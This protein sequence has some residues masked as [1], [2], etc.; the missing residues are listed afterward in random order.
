MNIRKL[1]ILSFC[2]QCLSLISFAQDIRTIETKVADLLAQLPTTDIQSTNKLMSDMILLGDGGIKQI[3]D[4][5]KPLGSGDDIRPRF[6]VESLSRYLSQYGKESEKAK[7]EQ[8]CI[9]YAT[10]QKDYTVNDFYMKQLQLVGSI[11][12][13][14]AIKGYLTDKNLNS[15]ALAVISSVGGPLAETV[16]SEALKD[17]MLPCAAA[18]MNELA[19]MKSNVAVNEF[20]AWSSNSDKSIQASA[21]NA[22][23]Q[24]GSPLALPVLLKA[25]KS[26]SYKWE[27]TGATASLLV[28]TKAIGAKGD[29]KT[30]DKICKTIITNCNDR[31]SIQYKTSALETLVNY[32]GYE[33]MPY[34]L[35]AARHQD[36]TYRNAAYLFSLSLAG[37]QVTRKWI[38]YYPEAAPA[39]KP[40]IIYMLGIRKDDLA[41]PLMSTSLTDA[42]V[43]VRKAAAEAIVK[44]NGID[45]IHSLIDYMIKFSGN[46]DQESAKSALMTVVDNRRMPLLI[47]V[48][49]AGPDAAKKSAIELFAWGKGQEYFAAVLPFTAYGEENVKIAA[50][51]ALCDIAGPGDQEKLIQLLNKTE[52]PVLISNVQLALANAANQE[53]DPEKRSST[54]L[55]SMITNRNKGMI[56]PILSRTGGKDALATVLKEFDNGDSEVRDVCFKALTSWKDYSASSA[57]Y[58]I[59][60]THNK[61]YEEAAFDGYVRQIKSA[62]VPDEQRLLLYR[63]IMP[64]AMSADLK[65]QIITEISKIKT[66]QA[67]FFTAGYLDDPSTSAAAAKAIMSIA[68][69]T[70]DSKAGMYGA[71]VIDILSKAINQLKGP[72]SEYDKEVISKYLKSMPQDDGFVS[73]FNGKNLTGWQGLVENPVARAKMKS[74]E[75]AKKQAEANKR[76]F[77]NWSVKDGCIWFNGSGDNLCSIKEY[78]DFELLVDWKIT[79]K[80]DSGI[81]LRGSPQVQIWDTSRIEVGA[82][83]GSGGLYNN[84]KNPSKP[85]K[86]TDNPIGDWNSFRIIMT[87]EKVTVWLNGILVVDNVTL[88][89]YWDRKIPIFPKGPIEL[90]AHGTDLAFRDIYVRE[91][92]EKDYNLT[93]EEKSDGFIA[94][95]NGRTLNGWVGDTLAYGVEDGM[96]VTIPSKGTIGNLYTQKEYVDFNIRFEFQLSPA[97]NNGLGIR[98]PLT[99]DAAYVGMELQILDNTAPIYARLHPY[100]YHGSVY[101]VIPAKTGYLKPLG[102]WNY[103]DVL[104]KGTHIKITLNGTVILDDDIANARD[105]GTMDHKQH[106]GLKN[107]TGHIGFLGHGSLVK[108]RNIRI[109][110]LSQ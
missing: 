109:K 44:I 12:S 86:V 58:Q 66:Y 19:I 87:G 77:E 74:V 65:N 27:Q 76:M 35:D 48:L 25:A 54:L 17:K 26:V 51:K 59:C 57:L 50:Y 96:I 21:L 29:V 73:M 102:E 56:I 99:G 81:Y 5:V 33:A 101:G 82:Q 95:F 106:P 94:L 110:D 108:F 38:E 55:K 13:I 91:I 45:A 36:K 53:S 14:E 8:L 100:Q 61:A 24:T 43:N 1:F 69:P 67:L 89:N 10:D 52:N 39:A 20:I 6:A 97:A 22:L 9:S 64:F 40:E 31:N 34:L 71:N 90:Q 88:E 79:K 98:A 85:L 68:L 11:A 28:Y 70:V 103:E 41:L 23:A 62:P 63:K 60:A 84:Q 93:Q 80:G 32:Y 92:S 18:A 15:P 104:V 46:E 7:W 78:G 105:N 30:M 4:Q 37:T 47:S 42:D 83:V 75:L 2:L 107:K 49:N 72:E 3:C 16:L